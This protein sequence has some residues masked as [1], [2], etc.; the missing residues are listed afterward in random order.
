M[1]IADQVDQR[2]ALGS[3]RTCKGGRKVAIAIDAFGMAAIGCGE[4][5]EVGIDERR[6]LDVAWV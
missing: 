3:Q 4:L 2:R 1:W 6:A 5:H